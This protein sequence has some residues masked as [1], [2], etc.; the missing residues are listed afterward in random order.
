[1]EEFN[2]TLNDYQKEALMRAG[3]DRYTN[4]PTAIIDHIYHLISDLES[5]NK[6]YTK[7]QYYKIVEIRDIL[8]PVYMNSMTEIPF[9]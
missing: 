6:N 7:A 5:H 9:C 4:N 3:Y 2:I 1:M 8:K